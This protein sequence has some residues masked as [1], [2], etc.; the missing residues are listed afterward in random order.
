M[1]P[2]LALY[3]RVQQKSACRPQAGRTV[4]EMGTTS[5]FLLGVLVGGWW[6]YGLGSGT[7]HAIRTWNDHQTARSDER[8]LRS[9]RWVAWRVVTSKWFWTI[10]VVALVLNAAG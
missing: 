9:A 5:V 4:R 2:G 1:R 6:C 3:S 8:R 7:R 10:V